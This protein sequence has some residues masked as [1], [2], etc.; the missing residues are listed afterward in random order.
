LQQEICQVFQMHFLDRVQAINNAY[1]DQTGEEDSSLNSKVAKK[2]P[3][4]LSVSDEYLS[5]SNPRLVDIE[6]KVLHTLSSKN[7]NKM[8]Q[9]RF[10]ITLTMLTQQGGSLQT[11]L[12][13]LI[14]WSSKRN[15]LKLKKIEF[16]CDQTELTHLIFNVKSATNSLE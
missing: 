16:E 3:A 7:V 10:Q 11:G 5:V 6:W 12:G 14:Q 8:F 9:P 1:E 15:Y 4:N 13:S 2:F